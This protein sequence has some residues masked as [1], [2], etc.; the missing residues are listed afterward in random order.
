M[1]AVPA[2][3]VLNV[4]SSS[5]K[6]RVLGAE[7]ALPVLLDGRV[8]G[9]GSRPE[10]KLDD[11]KP[12]A[13]DESTDQTAAIELVLDQVQSEDRRW[14]L[15][16]AG[17]RIVHGGEEFRQPVRLDAGCLERLE[18][19]TPLA[20]LHQRHNLA[21]VRVLAG[22][23][24][25]LPQVGCFDTAFHADHDAVTHS[26]ALPDQLRAAGIRRY[27]F[28]GLSY[29]WIA[30]LLAREP[31]GG[32]RRVVAAHLGNGA[33]LCAMQRG[34]SVDTTMGMT[35]LEGLPMGTRCGA[36]DPGAVIYMLRNCGLSV[37][38]AEQVLHD[39]SGLKG[40]SGGVSEMSALLASDSSRAEL[41]VRYFVLRTA[42]KI[43]E[44]MV[45]I[46]GMDCLVFTGGI[47]EH[48]GP[49]RER[50]VERLAFLPDFDVRV[51]P[52][53]EERMIAAHTLRF[54]QTA[55]NRGRAI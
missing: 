34:Q 26:Y 46:G 44:M 48:A 38:E 22:R 27:G 30:Q 32:P 7:T 42:Q 21:A 53:D 31:G 41:A 14:R 3:V 10:L 52:A 17:H 24:P 43:A 29:E 16:A 8:T 20:P 6:F 19:Y 11:Q 55:G 40:L 35:A 15:V 39:E 51:I 23:E 12:R 28:H 47:G 4:G 54:V 36:L 18:R 37:D 25:D 1:S 49:V 9:I 13:L 2:V 5:V 33:S 45:S 50:I